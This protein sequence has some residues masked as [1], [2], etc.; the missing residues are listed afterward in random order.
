MS[1][2][3]QELG[4][5]ILRNVNELCEDRSKINPFV[6]NSI[7]RDAEKTIQNDDAVT[8]YMVLGCLSYLEGK[9][10]DMIK[11]HDI[12]L[13]LAPR[14][15]H[16]LTNYSVSLN[17][18]GRY[19]KAYE[20]ARRALNIHGYDNID[21]L[22]HTFD[23]AL[24]AGLIKESLELSEKLEL[25]KTSYKHKEE[26]EYLVKL[27][28]NSQIS[29]EIINEYFSLPSK[30]LIDFDVYPMAL[31]FWGLTEGYPVREIFV[32]TEPEVAAQ[33]NENLSEIMASSSIPMTLMLEFNFVFTVYDQRHKLAV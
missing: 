5:K 17:N 18:T 14:D 7:R 15:Y 24:T 12:S 30:V 28:G 1:I 33:M 8:G 21:L 13:K 23:Y 3:P 32:S 26:L 25:Q 29:H 31:D 20:L 19:A 22:K 16:V 2:Q 9:T 11:F 10:S 27:M 4:K 6:I